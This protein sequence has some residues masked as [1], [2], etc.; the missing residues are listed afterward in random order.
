MNLDRTKIDLND[1]HFRR[2]YRLT[3][4]CRLRTSQLGKSDFEGLCAQ[5]KG[6]CLIKLKS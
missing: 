3:K 2:F 4:E 1:K 5:N 6:L